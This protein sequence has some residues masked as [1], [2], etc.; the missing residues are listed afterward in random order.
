[1]ETEKLQKI[2]IFNPYYSLRNDRKRIILCNAPA[3]KI[4][5]NIAEE[6]VSVFIHPA[7][8]VAFSLFNG[9]KTLNDILEE[10]SSIFE[11]PSENCLDF[12][13]SF[14]Q[15]SERVGIEYDNV[16]FELPKNILIENKDN[17]YFPRILNYEDYIIKEEL[18]FNT[19]RLFEA[20]TTISLLVNTVC[21]TDCIYCYVDRRIKNNCQ[22][23]IERLKELIREA[24]QLNVVNFDISGT[25]I[26]MY[27]HWEE[28]IKELIDNGYYPYLSTKLPISEESIIKIKNTGIKHLQLSIDTLDP[29]EAKVVNR[30]KSN[31]Y[32][33]KI[34]KT[35]RFLEKHNIIVAIN[36]VIT[37]YNSSFSGIKKL[38]DE[39]NTFSNIETFSINPAERS[40][41]CSD[42]DFDN[43]KNSIKEIEKLK[44]YINTIR[45]NYK[46]RI[47]FADYI[48]KT[49]FT[50]D[51][52]TK[53]ENHERRSMCTANIS[54]MCI[55][56]DGQ[57]TICEELYW[58]K[59][60]LIGNVLQNSIKEIWTSEKAIELSKQ[61][62]CNFSND[63]ICKYCP[64]FEDCRN[65]LG[66]CWSDVLAA[67]GE[68]HWDYPTPYCPYAPVPTYSMYHE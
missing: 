60:F 21:A 50:A 1:M 32:I 23:P 43:F 67:Y 18:D 54:Q 26:F 53:K 3:F 37:K 29:K 35:L 19:V 16:W 41:G 66:I 25:E 47:S 55:L 52:E 17:T 2:Y 30:N 63:S 33:S 58:S 11:T 65:V 28:L 48:S 9:K 39:L 6:D 8:A 27:K 5:P 61:N 31:N 7:F 24:K 44:S 40:L 42:K 14:L 20:P 4:P 34:F 46:F 38:L 51:I 62:P 59:R 13:S 57:V 68:E 15:N 22:I 64:Q 10:M 49:E 45:N 12:I 36:A 56:S